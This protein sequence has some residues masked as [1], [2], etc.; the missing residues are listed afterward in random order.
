[1]RRYVEEYTTL[2]VR[3]KANADEWTVWARPVADMFRQAELLA[4]HGRITEAIETAER[5]HIEQYGTM[6]GVEFRCVT[7]TTTITASAA[8]NDGWAT[9][10]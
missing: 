2:Q 6:C 4:Y 10:R 3:H 8:L 5:M 7:K 9:V 1:M